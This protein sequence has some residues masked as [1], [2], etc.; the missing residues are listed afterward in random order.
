MQVTSAAIS[1]VGLQRDHNEDSCLA[2]VEHGLFIVADGMGGAAAG[3]VASQI[4]VERVASFFRPR[5]QELRAGDLGSPAFRQR[6]SRLAEAAVQD[7]NQHV[8]QAATGESGRA[9]MGTTLTVLLLLDRVAVVAHVGDSRLYLKRNDTLYPLTQ[10]HSFVNEMVQRGMLD[11]AEALKHPMANLLTR[12]V[13]PQANVVADVNILD[14][15]N[16]DV[17][18]L[19]S[20]GVTKGVPD[21]EMLPV[22]T[23][24]RS[25]LDDATAALVKAA[26]DAGGDDNATVVLVQVA[27]A[28]D[29]V[30]VSGPHEQF[31]E[32]KL[33]ALQAL[34]LFQGL[35]HTELLAVGNLGGSLDLPTGAVVVEAG[36]LSDRFFVLLRGRVVLCLHGAEVLEIMPGMHFGDVECFVGQPAMLEAR[37]VTPSQLLVFERRHLED[38]CRRDP[39]LGVQLLWRFTTALS[40]RVDEV[41]RRGTLTETLQ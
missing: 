9:G 1:D 14:V 19:C 3:E 20:D 15:Y 10:D 8:Y 37:T 38:L 29:D 18:L 35:G 23:A 27:D 33:Q 26:N 16:G 6:L 12:A 24:A 17:F 13:G 41:L 34:P 40:Q 28:P 22:L 4:A 21:H 11:E 30:E 31:V 32:A 2:D 25:R 5:V 36:K 7:A 39:A